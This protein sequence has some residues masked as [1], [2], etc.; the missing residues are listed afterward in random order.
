VNVDAL[1]GAA[2]SDQSLDAAERS[3]LLTAV[4]HGDQQA[5]ERLTNAHLGLVA[6]AARDR[7]DRE[8]SESDLFQEGT[9]GLIEAIEGFRTAARQ[10]FEAYASERI[11]DHMDRAL[12]NEEKAV[13]ASQQLIRAAEDYVRTE[14]ALRQE[15]G[16]AATNAE[17]A[18]KLE[19]SVERTVMIGEMVADARRRHD[20]EL[21]QYLDPSDIDLDT[22]IGDPPEANGE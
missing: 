19:W 18:E 15:L 9:I 6:Q 20:E 3:R 11:A 2:G 4:A 8:L 13:Q 12:D 5:R 1:A 10:D 16:R 21:L 14:I 7:A 22:L 17:V